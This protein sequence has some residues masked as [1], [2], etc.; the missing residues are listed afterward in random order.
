[1]GLFDHLYHLDWTAQY[2]LE[3]YY[4]DGRHVIFD[5]YHIDMFGSIYNKKTGRR[6]HCFI[7]G[8][9]Y[10]KI[11]VC[12]SNGK[13]NQIGVARAVV[14][15]FHGKPP[16]LFHS[17]EH[18]D[19]T[20]KNN[21]IVSELTWVEPS[22]Q[23]KNRLS[24]EE[25][26]SACVIVRGDLEMTGKEWV[27]HLRNEKNQFGRNYT[28]SMIQ[29]CAQ[30]KQHGFS[31]KVYENLPEE[32]W[33]NISNS[34]SKM[35]RWEIS[36]QNRIAY[37]TTHARNV[38]DATRFGFSGKYPQIRIKGK[39]RYLHDVA[40]EAYFPKEYTAKKPGEMILHKYDD[41]LDFRPHTIYIGNASTNGKDAHDNGSYN[42]TKRA[43]IP[44]ISYINDVFEKR[45]ECQL[46]AEKYLKKMGY[47][48]ASY[49]AIGQALKSL[50]VLT[51]YDRTWKLDI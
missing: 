2:I 47:E 43:R 25:Q 27:R 17:T 14:S 41:K 19:C 18:I 42:D 23:V 1:M 34:E 24:S 15:T 38:I 30:N 29:K 49:R 3:Y 44:C 35:G 32:K 20:N 37:V 33:Y 4:N 21:D 39:Q 40:F 5:R 13:Q 28:L 22:G 50:K 16:T 45:H 11:N 48:K 9:R 8:D 31:Y 46:D 6:V 26:S 51:K 7:N 12:D 10:N 36:D